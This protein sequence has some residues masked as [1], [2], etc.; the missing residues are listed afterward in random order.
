MMFEPKFK[1]QE[2]FSYVKIKVIRVPKITNSKK[3]IYFFIFKKQL[4]T[5]WKPLEAE[6]LSQE[7]VGG[8]KA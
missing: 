8:D 5:K 6:L 4:V 1:G 2:G 3:Y 7:R